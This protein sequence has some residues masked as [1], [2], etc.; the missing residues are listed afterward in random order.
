LKCKLYR[1]NS[2]TDP[3]HPGTTTDDRRPEKTQSGV[4]R[5]TQ[6]AG[7]KEYVRWVYVLKS[8]ITFILD[9]TAIR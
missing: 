3:R 7:K 4:G 9:P 8:I 2:C 6:K 5:K 1:A